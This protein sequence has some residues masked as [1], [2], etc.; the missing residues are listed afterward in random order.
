MCFTIY[1]YIYIYLYILFFMKQKLHHIKQFESNLSQYHEIVTVRQV[2]IGVRHVFSAEITDKKREYILSTSDVEHCFGDVRCFSDR[3]GH[4]FRCQKVHEICP[5]KMNIDILA[6][7]PSCKDL[8]SLARTALL[9]VSKS[10]YDIYI[11]RVKQT[12]VYKYI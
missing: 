4:C 6:V 10:F 3:K 11:Y 9:L 12:Y 5:D 7:G 1:I 8:S 2:S